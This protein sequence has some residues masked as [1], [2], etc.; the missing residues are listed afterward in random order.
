[1]AI[2]VQ[3][4]LRQH[5]ASYFAHHRWP[6]HVHRAAQAMQ[7]C[8]TAALGGHVERCPNGH[9]Q[10]VHYNSCHHRSCPACNALPSERW[11]SRCKARLLS[12]DHRHLVF[13]VAQEL[14]VF[15]RYNR[16]V[17]SRILF[18]AVHDTLL[19]LLED[20]K[21]Q[22]ATPGILAA[23]HT[24]GQLLQIHLHVHV[25]VTAGGLDEAGKWRKAK[26]KCLLP[27]KVVMS[28]YRGKLL[29]KLRRAAE[30][31]ELVLPEGWNRSRFFSLLNKLGRVDWNVKI[32]EPY[33]H[34]EGVATY[35]ARYARGGPINNQRLLASEEGRVKFGYRDNR[36]ADPRTGRGRRKTAE[37]SVDE[38]LSRLFEHVP[39]PRIQTVRG[40]GLY[41][42]SKQ[43]DL[44]AARQALG[45]SPAG[46]I[47]EISYRQFL[48]Q[49]GYPDP[50]RCP[51]CQAKLVTAQVFARGRAPPPQSTEKIA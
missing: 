47:E 3:S 35:L 34:G 36:D 40:W 13:T 11:L 38:F 48:L 14:N 17:F 12:T 6:L 30:K 9:V 19:V 4:I 21:Y 28:L 33:P 2:S 41:A 26:K 27:R 32:L 8:R 29:A 51:V 10:K 1:M 49:A 42:S 46:N 50:S 18:S 43:E 45:H 20:K 7:D 16:V 25:L 22:G 44:A 31:G 23:L 37:M 39:P 15:W 24:W 5:A